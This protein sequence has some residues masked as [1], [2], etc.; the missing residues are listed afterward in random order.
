[1]MQAFRRSAKPVIYVV[2]I[3]FFA[4]LVLDLSGLTGGTGLLTATS[5]GKINGESVDVRSFQEAVSRLTEQRQRQSSEPLGIAEMAQIRDQVWD[6]F[7]QQT[8]LE[9]EYDRWGI[10]VTSAEVAEAIRSAPPSEFYQMTEFQTDGKFDP[11]K[12]ERWLAS[13]VG[14][15]YVPLM[16]EQYRTQILQAK[17][18]RHLVAS[19]YVSEAELWARYRDMN[20]RVQGGGVNVPTSAISDAAIS[21]TPSEVDEFYRSRR[22][23]FRRTRTAF[24]SYITLDRRPIASDTAAALARAQAI[25]AEIVAGAPFAEVARRES[26]DTVSGSRGGDLGQWTRGAF[27]VAFEQAAASLPLNR[28]SEPALTRFGYHLIEVTSRQRDT[29]AGRHILIPIELAGAHRDELDAKADSLETLAADRLDPAALDTAARALGLGIQHSG[30]IVKGQPSPVVPDAGVWAFQATPGEHS[31]VVE[32]PS[33]YYVFRAD[34]LWEEGIPPL[35]EVRGEV[36]NR[37]REQKKLAEARRLAQEV[38][39]QVAAGKSL[40]QAA[41]DLGLKYEVLGP[42]DRINAPAIGPAAVGAVFGMQPGQPSG[43]LE[44]PSGYFLVEVLA[45]FP[46]DSAEFTRQLPQFREQVLNGTRQLFLQQYFVALRAR[47]RIV[48]QRDRIFRTEAQVEAEAAKQP[49]VP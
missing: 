28:V 34:S 19:L 26:A 15:G 14:Q 30:P 18:A 32:T 49:L 48:D 1:M 27:D 31:P 47:A 16:E 7:V 36:E 20:E 10:T 35:E 24:L 9:A 25:R 22:E 46:A 37:L 44:T 12:Y 21:V 42:F 5:V 23:E 11:S 33:T 39:N 4:W 17:L 41:A 8:L 3:S 6:Q 43:P 45:R 13:A 2:A 40:R 29:T 38:L